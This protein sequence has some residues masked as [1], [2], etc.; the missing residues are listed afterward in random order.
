MSRC[1]NTTPIPP[2]ACD[3]LGS[4]GFLTSAGGLTFECYEYDAWGCTQV[5][6]SLYNMPKAASSYGLR[7]LFHGAAYSAATGLY[8]FRARWYSPE[9]GRWLSP[10]PIGLEGGL[11]LYEFCRNDPVNFRDP[12]GLWNLWSPGS[13]GVANSTAWNFY[14]S[15]NPFHES[16][17]LWGENGGAM[18]G[19]QGA[20]AF[21]DGVNPFGDPLSSFYLDEC[22][23]AQNGTQWSRGIGLSLIHI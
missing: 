16:S 9:L 22:G 20:A 5:Q 7:F 6:N 1:P 18:G 15:L 21:L 4:V 3:A 8:Q 10:D 2:A 19:L 14:D 17:G 12:S 13:W 11:N 23:N